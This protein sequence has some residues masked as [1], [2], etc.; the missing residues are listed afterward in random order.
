MEYMRAQIDRRDAVLAEQRTEFYQQLLILKNLVADADEKKVLLP[1]QLNAVFLK[2]YESDYRIELKRKGSH[3]CLPGEKDELEYIS[4]ISDLEQRIK[5][6]QIQHSA[7][8]SSLQKELEVK[9]DNC[10]E[11]ILHTKRAR[12]QLEN[13][14]KTVACLEESLREASSAIER[15]ETEVIQMQEEA[16]RSEKIVAL[17]RQKVAEQSTKIIEAETAPSRTDS[18]ISSSNDSDIER[19]WYCMSVDVLLI[20]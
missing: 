13:E 1:E 2:S 12:T 10:V 7:Q 18:D 19:E 9:Q 3:V 6:M 8:L 14:R 5:T 20:R 4:T 11:Q 17:L 15:L 16:D